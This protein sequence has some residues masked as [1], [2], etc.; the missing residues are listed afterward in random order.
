M[1]PGY[2]GALAERQH[3]HKSKNIHEFVL[4]DA[5]M[6]TRVLI[7][8]DFPNDIDTEPPKHESCNG[9]TNI[10]QST[11]AILEGFPNWRTLLSMP[12]V[13]ESMMRETQPVSRKYL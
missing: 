4:S 2:E 10:Q 6:S 13:S 5:K 11:D 8:D 3:E 1:E 7:E 12:R 9:L